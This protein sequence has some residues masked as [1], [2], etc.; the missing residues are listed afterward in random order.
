MGVL[1][2][3]RAEMGCCRHCVAC[4]GCCSQCQRADSRWLIA[5]FHVRRVY[6]LSLSLAGLPLI[7]PTL[8]GGAVCV[9]GAQG[10]GGGGSEG[11]NA[12]LTSLTLASFL[13]GGWGVG[14]VIS[15]QGGKERSTAFYLSACLS[16]FVVSSVGDESHVKP[17]PCWFSGA[18]RPP[19]PSSPA[20]FSSPRTF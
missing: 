6:S 12:S 9:L 15:S 4:G 16:R 7:R 19:P 17:I 10:V 5:S 20:P 3:S 8:G 2:P 11:G 14:G 1:P 13:G 18:L